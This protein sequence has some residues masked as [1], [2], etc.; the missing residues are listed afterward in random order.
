LRCPL[1][2]PLL[3]V[4]MSRNAVIRLTARTLKRRNCYAYSGIVSSL[5]NEGSTKRIYGR[6]TY[7]SADGQVLG[8]SAPCF[9]ISSVS[10]LTRRFCTQSDSPTQEEL[11]KITTEDRDLQNSRTFMTS[12]TDFWKGFVDPSLQNKCNHFR[13]HYKDYPVVVRAILETRKLWHP[14]CTV[15]I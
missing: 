6:A 3:L 12:L 8:R 14:T 4:A 11:A 2:L 10:L 7:N 9:G 1:G 15:T 13:E 5:A